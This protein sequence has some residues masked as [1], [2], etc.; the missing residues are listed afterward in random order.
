MTQYKA[1]LTAGLAMFAMFFGSGNLVFPI[2]IGAK[3][4]DQ[5]SIATIGLMLTGVMVPFL[6]LFSMVIFQGD[7]DKYFGLLGKFAPFILSFLILSLIGPFGVAP[8]CLLVSYGG[9]SLLYPDIPVYLFGIIFVVLVYFIIFKQDKIVPIIGKILGPLKIAGIVL[10]IIA[11]IKDSPTLIK[12]NYDG[13]PFIFGLVEGYQTMDLMASFFFSMTIVEYLK[14][15]S[16]SKEETLSLS[17]RAGFLGAILIAV[18]YFGFVY[19]GAHYSSQL[20]NIKPEQ[21]IVTIAEL[22]LGRYATWVVSLT[23]AL[24]CLVTASTLVKLFAE[25]LKKDLARDKLNWQI[26]VILTLIVT[27]ILSLIGFKTIAGFL[28][29]ILVYAYPALISLSIA[30]ILNY[31]YNFKWI[32][33]TF[34][35][36]LIVAAILKHI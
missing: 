2:M 19:L 7:K 6:G 29:S 25:F 18:I 35:I 34:W 20:A 1:I 32:K 30:S 3:T 16:S 23:I 21:Y 10:I 24:S 27:F 4:A 5:Y 13:N 17:L 8:R 26:S 31:Y 22:T 11:A 28:A 36:T 9:I 33:E 12:G 14:S 15:I